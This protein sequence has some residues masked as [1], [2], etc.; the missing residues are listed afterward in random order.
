[1]APET[2]ARRVV[3]PAVLGAVWP[4]AIAS[5][6]AF[7]GHVTVPLLQLAHHLGLDASARLMVR[8]IDAALWSAIFGALFGIP[9]GVI[10]RTKVIAAWLVF[11]VA[12]LV[13]SLVDGSRSQ[14][15]VGIVLLAWSI[16]E[17]WL[18]VLA[19]LGFA[20]CTAH[21][22]ARREAPRGVAP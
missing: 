7:S 18:Y 13:V 17:T 22:I 19:V 4:F 15:G 14:M 6:L 16:P 21:F 8:V 12:L 5:L 20:L 9:L 10:A 3:L 2:R 1:M 11:V